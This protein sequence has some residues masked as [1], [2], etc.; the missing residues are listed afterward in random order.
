MQQVGR[1]VSH[2]AKAIGHLPG[3]IDRR[4]GNQVTQFS[5]PHRGWSLLETQAANRPPVRM[6]HTLYPL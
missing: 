4:P 2:T 5:C 3:F 6:A 1:F